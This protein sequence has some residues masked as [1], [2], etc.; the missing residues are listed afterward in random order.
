MLVQRRIGE[1]ERVE[2]RRKRPRVAISQPFEADVDGKRAFVVDISVAGIRLAEPGKPR[3][4]GERAIIS[5]EW[6]GRPASFV[7]EVRWLQV[8]QSI[9]RASYA[10]S[11]YQVG[12][13]IIDAAPES[14]ALMDEILRRQL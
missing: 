9:G 3:A 8:Q 1:S 13:H 12:Y 2:Q 4:V 6:E 14:H 10:H 11:F 7:C 5:F